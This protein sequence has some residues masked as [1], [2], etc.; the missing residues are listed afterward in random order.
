MTTR[1]LQASGGKFI[2]VAHVL[3]FIGNG[4]SQPTYRLI[5]ERYEDVWVRIE[6]QD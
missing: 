3:Y 2:E 1:D 6:Q 5:R 4:Q